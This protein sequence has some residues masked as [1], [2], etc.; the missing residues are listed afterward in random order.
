[1]KRA[2][3]RMGFTLIELLVV[4]AIIAILMG[5][6]LPAVQKVR[7]AAAR[8]TCQNNLKQLG[9]A[10]FNHHSAFAKFPQPRGVYPYEV[11]HFTEWKGWPYKILP[12]IEQDNLQKVADANYANTIA[13]NVKI[14]E[15]PSDPRSGKDG[16][17]ATS[18]F[19]N[20]TAGLMWYVGVTGSVGMWPDAFTP[21]NSGV[22][23]ANSDGIRISDI[24]DGTSNTLL[25][26][27][28]PPSANL[29]WGWWS[30]SDYDNILA[31]QDFIGSVYIYSGCSAPGIYRRGDLNNNC[32][33]NHFWSLHEGGANWAFA[34]GSVHFLPY[35]A[36]AVTIPMATRAGG[37]V[38]DSGSF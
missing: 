32:D 23:Q 24:A 36:A 11:T 16:Q 20:V 22:F 10:L 21:T 9:I 14:F 13:A 3:L 30:F 31:T 25:L 34:D 15:C 26:G 8:A 38:V 7:G 29:A 17:Y 37:E 12:F 18:A 1:M 19:G 4:I 6:F 33:S 5:L 28:R 35:S 2:R 27:E